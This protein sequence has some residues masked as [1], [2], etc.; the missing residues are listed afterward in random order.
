MRE[1]A[2][3]ER[4]DERRQLPRTLAHHLGHVLNFKQLAGQVGLDAKTARLSLE[5]SSPD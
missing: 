2:D 4:L 3:L 1:I 5:L